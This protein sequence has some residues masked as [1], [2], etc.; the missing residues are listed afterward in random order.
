LRALRLTNRK[1]S[2][3][4]PLSGVAE[5]VFK[6]LRAST[7]C[8]RSSITMPKGQEKGKTTNKPKLSVKEK[9]AKKKEKLAAKGS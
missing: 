6:K 1:L 5:G 9:K 2:E 8:V 7:V 4:P 3:K